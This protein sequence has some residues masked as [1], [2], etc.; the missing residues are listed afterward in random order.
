MAKRDLLAKLYERV[1]LGRRQ[2]MQ[3]DADLLR[4]A[5]EQCGL[6][7]RVGRG[8]EQ[9]PLRLWRQVLHAAPEARFHSHRDRSLAR[10][11]V[12]TGKA[13]RRELTRQLEQREWITVCLGEY[14]LPHALVQGLADDRREQFPRIGV[15][16][17]AEPQLR[18]AAQF[19]DHARVAL[20]EED[21]DRL[22]RQ[23]PGHE[24]ENLC[25]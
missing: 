1:L 20:C 9:Q 21:Q 24:S 6:T 4:G 10:Q 5:D 13:A 16:Q 23:A 15:R 14:P 12:T 3:L 2:L 22:S 8:H 25:G 18:Q 11:T 7:R 17:S 19:L